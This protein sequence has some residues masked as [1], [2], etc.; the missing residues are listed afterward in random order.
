MVNISGS[1]GQ[2]GNNNAADVETVKRRFVQLGFEINNISTQTD[3]ETC[4]AELIKAIKLFQ[5][6][7]M[8]KDTLAHN[9]VDGLIEKNRRTHSALRSATAPHWVEM[10]D[11]SDTGD[12]PALESWYNHEKMIGGQ[13]AYWCTSWLH[14]TI[15][16]AAEMYRKSHPSGQPIYTAKA[17]R[18][19]GGLDR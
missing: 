16:L 13:D 7:I 3:W 5:A 9:Q 8:G 2:G 18:S 15:K 12:S 17:T 6:I 10:D 11:G 1:V 14:D 4:D 19:S